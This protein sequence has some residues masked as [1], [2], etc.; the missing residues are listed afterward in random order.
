MAHLYLDEEQY[1][2]V[3]SALN[4][5]AEQIDENNT[6]LQTLFD[7]RQAFGPSP[8]TNSGAETVSITFSNVTREEA[9]EALRA[10]KNGLAQPHA[11]TLHWLA[12]QL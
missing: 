10:T 3:V 5:R 11:D 8:E 2:S 7:I 1:Q 6:E 9:K 12:D 4:A